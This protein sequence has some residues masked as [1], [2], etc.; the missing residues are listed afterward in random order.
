MPSKTRYERH[1]ETEEKRR[2]I[3]LKDINIE[4]IQE[5]EPE[6]EIK[7]KRNNEEEKTKVKR[8]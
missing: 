6:Q 5:I 7:L 4:K 8:K 3:K 2:G 1:N